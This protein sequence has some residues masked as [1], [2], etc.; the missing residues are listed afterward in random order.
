MVTMAIS[1]EETCENETVIVQEGGSLTIGCCLKKG[2]EGLHCLEPDTNLDQD[3]E[4]TGWK[5][6]WGNGD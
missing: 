5:I 1:K 2:H 3:S 4:N 6:T